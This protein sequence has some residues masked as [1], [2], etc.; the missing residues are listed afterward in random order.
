MELAATD[1][2]CRRRRA[3]ADRRGEQHGCGVTLGVRSTPSNK[4]DFPPDWVPPANTVTA[5]TT[6][7]PDA[8]L[9]RTPQTPGDTPSKRKKPLAESHCPRQGSVSE[10]SSTSIGMRP[11]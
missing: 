10:R 2:K 11:A 6:T 3:F 5:F 4:F 7:C 8:S 1:C 9:A